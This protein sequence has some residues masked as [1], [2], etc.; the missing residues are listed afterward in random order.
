MKPSQGII[1]HEEIS[2]RQTITHRFPPKVLLTAVFL[3]TLSANEQAHNPRHISCRC[4]AHRVQ[5]VR[6]VCTK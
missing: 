4:P 3:R 1:D 2:K 5:S 6:N